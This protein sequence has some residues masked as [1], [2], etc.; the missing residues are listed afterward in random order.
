MIDVRPK[1]AFLSKKITALSACLL[2]GM[3]GCHRQQEPATSSLASSG[4]HPAKEIA[5]GQ[6]ARPSNPASVV[7]ANPAPDGA[8]P[9]VVGPVELSP[10]PDVVPGQVQ[11]FPRV[12]PGPAVTPDIAS[13]INAALDHDEAAAKA[14]ALTCRDDLKEAQPQLKSDDLADAWQRSVDVTMRGPRFLSYSMATSESCGGAYPEIARSSSIVY[15]L[16]TGKP[17]NW[18]RMLPR[19]T[20]GVRGDLGDGLVAGWIQVPFLQKQA[21]Q[22]AGE[23]C[24]AEFDP[25]YGEVT[26]FEVYPD[27]RSGS[28]V[29]DMPDIRHASRACEAVFSLKQ[30]E[31][32]RLGAPPEVWQA[33]TAAH[34]LQPK[35]RPR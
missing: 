35:P 19:G 31:L 16:S 30:P 2:L 32:K 6:Q 26:S 34:A 25:E 8:L 27:A 20:T 4:G 33:I 12:M 11:G 1:D 21:Y 17:V 29:L 14:S 9:A 5:Q 28:L 18:L 10:H 15:D 3:S 13:R 24:K 23:D 22:D 7:A